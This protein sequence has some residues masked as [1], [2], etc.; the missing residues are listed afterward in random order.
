MR[1]TLTIVGDALVDR[2]L[3]EPAVA[4]AA[5]AASSSSHEGDEDEEE[6]GS[7]STGNAGAGAGDGSAGAGRRREVRAVGVRVRL[8]NGEWTSLR[9]V[10]GG[11]V[12]RKRTDSATFHVLASLVAF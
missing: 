11:T 4:S 8:S 3:L 9:V 2:V 10:A 6:D 7:S 1:P 12:V 5:A